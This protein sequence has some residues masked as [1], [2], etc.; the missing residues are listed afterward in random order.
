MTLACAE[1]RLVRSKSIDEVTNTLICAD[2]RTELA[3]FPGECVDMIVTSPPYSQQ[4]DYTTPDQIGNER[5]A[6]EYIDQLLLVLRECK[7]VLKPSGTLWLN[8]GDKYLNSNLLGLPWR[9]AIAMQ[10][11]VGW[12]LRSD[13]ITTQTPFGNHM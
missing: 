12:L 2:S 7:R 6:T 8:L 13:I 1:T 3:T 11:K 10:D 9:V 5:S 4:R